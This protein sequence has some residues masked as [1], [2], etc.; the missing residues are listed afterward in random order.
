[1]RAVLTV[2]G[3]DEVGILAKIAGECAKYGVNINEVTQSVLQDIFCMIMLCDISGLNVDFGE[4]ADKM[5]E[6]GKDTGLAVNVMHSEIFDS[7]HRI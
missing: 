7:M 1:M 6:V 2:V 3:K 5:N 4:F